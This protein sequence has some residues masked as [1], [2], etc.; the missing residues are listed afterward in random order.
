MYSPWC[1]ITLTKALGEDESS[2]TDLYNFYKTES[3]LSARY[4]SYSTGYLRCKV[5]INGQVDFIP[6]ISTYYITLSSVQEETY[7][8]K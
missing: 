4:G 8:V 6:D 1:L 3:L 5:R 7:V 2:M